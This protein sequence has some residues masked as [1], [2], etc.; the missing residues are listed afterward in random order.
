M[1]DYISQMVINTTDCRSCCELK[2]KAD[3][4]EEWKIVIDQA[5]GC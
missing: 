5:M 2:G 4:C 1:A 3:K